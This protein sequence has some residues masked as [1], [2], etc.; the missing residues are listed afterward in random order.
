M[1]LPHPYHTPVPA[2]PNLTNSSSSAASSNSSS[3]D[4]LGGHA[5][6]EVV[7]IAFVTGSLSLVT[8]VGNLLV[9]IAFRV[10]SHLRTVNNYFLLSLAC[11]D[12]VLGAVSMN[13]YTTY[14]ITGRWTLGN[15]ACD[16]WLALDYVASNASVMNL[17][18]ISFDRFFSVT[19]P[20]TYRAKRTPRR[21]AIMIGLAWAISFVLWAPAI[22]F[23]QYAEGTRTVPPEECSIQF[24]SQPIITFG[25]AIAAFYLPVTIMIILYWRVYRETENR[26]RELP[27]LL[28]SQAR[29]AAP[30]PP[31]PGPQPRASASSGTT[32]TSSS[33]SSSESPAGPQS[34]GRGRGEPPGCCLLRP[35]QPLEERRRRRRRR[36]RRKAPPQQ[37]ERTY[38]EAN[39]NGNWN[40]EEEG[41][42]DSSSEGEPQR[43]AKGVYAMVARVPLIRAGGGG[44]P[45]EAG[46]GGVSDP[47]LARVRASGSGN[48][49]SSSPRD[50]LNL[51]SLARS[52]PGSPKRQKRRSQSLI[53]EKKAARTL[54]AI[55]LAFILTWTPY[56]IMVLVSPFC[57]KC[58]PDTLW[59]LGYWLCYVNST[60]NPMC[61]A[62]CSKSF[63]VTFR[64]LL[65]CRWDKRQWGKPHP[66]ARPSYCPSKTSSSTV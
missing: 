9:M 2:H 36:R 41:S 24:F 39:R 18:V 45:A 59:Q 22:L 43:E 57:D 40:G 53:K 42:E 34:P 61:Y 1:P 7:L 3:A 13:L 14:I 6:W 60:V 20:L 8:I 10:N 46:G 56:N 23:W 62:L 28:G 4:P 54:S 66:S 52:S 38:R 35:K 17:L 27:G 63:R 65:F 50:S 44:A 51:S 48:S 49:S 21:A 26:A 55:L 16:L 47:G 12:L 33:S 58:V 31:P 11:A 30:P 37:G 25:T 19:R 64:M 29:G 32:T 15:L 5:V